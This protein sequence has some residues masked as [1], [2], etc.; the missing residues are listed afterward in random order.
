MAHISMNSPFGP[1]TIF[2]ESLEDGGA[3]IALEWGR[4]ESPEPTA[5]LETARDQ[6]N[7]YF[8]GK[9]KDFDL[10]LSLKGTPYQCAVWDR[11]RRIPYGHVQTYGDIARGL[12]SAPRAVGGACGR[13]PIPII[14]PC[15][16]I[17]ASNGKLGGF[18][19]IG[20]VETKRALLRLEGYSIA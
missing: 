4:A 17:I 20:G 9:R 1:L 18:S 3:I 15:H 2:E 19:A 7:G 6:L 13:N 14:I 11:M 16:R 8:D 10:P 5:L 12:K